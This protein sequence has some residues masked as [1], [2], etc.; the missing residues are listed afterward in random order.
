M[1]SLI[2]LVTGRGQNRTEGQLH[3]FDLIEATDDRRPDVIKSRANESLPSNGKD[4]RQGQEIKAYLHCVA[5]R[6]G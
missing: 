3:C 5:G 1:F 6:Q 2:S 4:H